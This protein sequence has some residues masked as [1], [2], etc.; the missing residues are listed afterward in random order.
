M[1]GGLLNSVVCLVQDFDPFSTFP[2]AGQHTQ[3]VSRERNVMDEEEA[4]K[5]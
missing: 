1:G 5:V 3:E 4:E 2:R